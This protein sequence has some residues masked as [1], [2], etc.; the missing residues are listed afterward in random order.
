MLREACLLKAVAGIFLATTLSALTSPAASAQSPDSTVVPRVDS[1]SPVDEVLRFFLIAHLERIDPE[2]QDADSSWDAKVVYAIDSV[3]LAGSGPRAD[4]VYVVAPLDWCGSG[5]CT[6]LVIDRTAATPRI[7][8]E[9]SL[10]WQPIRVLPTTSHGWHDLGLLV[11]SGA[12]TWDT[13]RYN[14]R[15]YRLYRSVPLSAADTAAGQAVL[16]PGTS[17]HPLYH[18]RRHLV[19]DERRDCGLPKLGSDKHRGSRLR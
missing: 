2:K 12:E 1:T 3:S 14:G 4:L 18:C 5:G 7:V 9:I 16:P 6:T 8:A 13:Y 17:E 15:R 19:G 11:G 10:T